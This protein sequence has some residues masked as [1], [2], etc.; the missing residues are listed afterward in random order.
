MVFPFVILLVLAFIVFVLWKTSR[1]PSKEFVHKYERV[2]NIHTE[3]TAFHYGI[4][5]DCGSSG[6]RI[7][8]YYWPPHTGN[9]H[10]LL[11]LHQMMDHDN[12]PIRM[13]IKPGITTYFG[14]ILM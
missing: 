11:R 4:V 2:A 9:P 5:I 7:F 12:H 10:E 14:L 3:K 1:D 8:I 6:S 13:K